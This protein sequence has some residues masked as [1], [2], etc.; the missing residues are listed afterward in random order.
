MSSP[1]TLDALR[2]SIEQG[3]DRPGRRY[4]PIERADGRTE[5]LG[6]FRGYYH[7]LRPLRF[8]VDTPSSLIRR[9]L[10]ELLE[11][12]GCQAIYPQDGA[13]DVESCA[14]AAQLQRSAAEE[15]ASRRQRSLSGKVL[16]HAA[17]FGVII[18]DDG[19]RIEC[20][21][22]RGRR[23]LPERLLLLMAQADSREPDGQ[24]VVLE[25][26]AESDT[27]S[28]FRRQGI[29]VMRAG[30]TREA[31]VRAMRD[32]KAAWGASASGRVYTALHEPTAD[33][34]SALTL[35]L[36]VLSRSDQTLSEAIRQALADSGEQG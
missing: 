14:A 29:G 33:A 36:A 15:I 19:E 20:V 4:G 32:A 23:C 5:Y 11:T 18:D 7:A 27:V 2:R 31:M 34:L 6:R 8:I 26:E 21:D 35:L 30:T 17:D 24:T 1:G 25:E 13:P 3:F 28:A 16:G 22:E 12:V 10:D 9:D